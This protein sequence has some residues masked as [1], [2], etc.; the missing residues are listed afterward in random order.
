MFKKLSLRAARKALWTSLR[1]LNKNSRSYYTFHERP[2]RAA[3]VGTV[4]EQ[5]LV[6]EPAAIVIQGPVYEP[7]EFTLD[8]IRLYRRQMPEVRTILSTWADTPP[9]ILEKVEKAGGDVVLS[10][11]PE[12]FGLYNINLHITS[13][14]AGVRRAAELGAQW[15]MKTRTDQRLYNE[16]FL[17]FLIAL[18][19][20]FPVKGD[21]QQK[22]RIVGIGHG[23]LKYAP[24]HV[25][26][27]TVFGQVDDMVAYWDIPLRDFEPPAHWPKT[28]NEIHHG[29]PIGELCRLGVA[30]SHFAS[31]FLMKV[32]RSLEWTLED[33]WAAYRDQ[34]LFVDL[35]STDFY[36]VK[37]QT[38]SLQEIPLYYGWVSNRQEVDFREWFLLYSGA[39]PIEA[40]RRYE[41]ALETKFESAFPIQD[42]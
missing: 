8:T 10:E 13:A 4:P 24:Y 21:F 19:K 39:L 25:T 18:S 28:L 9:D 23:T 15:V 14:A 22:S 29:V 1:H 38:L 36:W 40:A 5:E 32:G 42:G 20:Q 3:D 7:D 2:K 26:D 33:T 27:Q 41:R 16:R 6:T 30:E 31:Q 35:S 11:K 17:S 37:A 12:K 34:F